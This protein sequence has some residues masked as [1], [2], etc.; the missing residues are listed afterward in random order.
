MHDFQNI[1][2]HYSIYHIRMMQHLTGLH[3]EFL[4]VLKRHKNRKKSQHYKF[5]RIVKEHYPVTRGYFEVF[6]GDFSQVKLVD[7]RVVYLHGIIARDTRYCADLSCSMDMK[8]I[9]SIQSLERSKQLTNKPIIFHS[10]QGSQYGSNEFKIWCQH[11]QITQSMS[12][13]GTPSDNP[14]MECFFA[15]IKDEKIKGMKFK[16][17]NE[18]RKFCTTIRD[19]Y[20]NLRLHQGIGYQYPADLF[21]ENALCNAISA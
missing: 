9:R 14:V 19:W 1:N 6:Y 10:D 11:H 4:Q 7:G 3:C 8:A 20:N 12:R 13:V 16:N 15:R 17:L 5:A 21:R 18:V 2:C